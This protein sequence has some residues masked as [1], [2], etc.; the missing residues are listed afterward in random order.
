MNTINKQPDETRETG[1]VIMP[2]LFIGHGSPLNAVETNRFSEGWRAVGKTLP[3]PRV[4]ICISAHWETKGTFVTAMEKPRTIHDFYGFPEKLYR[5]Q[6]PSP[7]SP[8]TARDIVRAGAKENIRPDLEWGLD[9][10]AWSVLTHLFPE[11]SFPVVQVSLNHT[12]RPEEHYRLAGILA[13]LRKKGALILA[14]G[15]LVHN[16]RL[17]SA[18]KTSEGFP[19][20]EE[21]QSIIKT[22]I[23]QFDHSSLYDYQLLGQSIRLAVPTP[24]HF[25]PVLY[26]L[27]QRGK[28]ERITWFNDHRVMGSVS[29]TSFKIS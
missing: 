11:A 28:D 10:G 16:L 7:G 26:A 14:S 12:L 15:N 18:I 19:W 6:Y 24:E 22:K 13:P 25:L 8:E 29:M 4:V 9:H 2:V 5:V 1:G 3:E 23:D 27:A 21:A 20:A 17:M